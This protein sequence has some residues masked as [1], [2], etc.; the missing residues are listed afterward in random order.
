MAMA[1]TRRRVV[2]SSDELRERDLLKRAHLAE[3]IAEALIGR[4]I[5]RVSAELAGQA[6]AERR[7]SA[8]LL[9]TDG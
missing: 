5:D 6:L 7:L 9:G 3:V 8:E 2:A 1:E 4:G